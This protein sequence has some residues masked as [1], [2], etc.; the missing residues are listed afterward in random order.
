MTVTDYIAEQRKL[1][2]GT[3][4][5]GEKVG[6]EVG[7]ENTA[8]VK[9]MSGTTINAKGKSFPDK[10]A[11]FFTSLFFPK[12]LDVGYFNSI[13]KKDASSVFNRQ[14]GT[15]YV[16]DRN[17]GQKPLVQLTVGKREAL[18]L[19]YSVSGGIV[20]NQ[21]NSWDTGIVLSGGLGIGVEKSVPITK[22]EFIN[23]CIDVVANSVD[24][25][26]PTSTADIEGF[27]LN[28][29]TGA[30]LGLSCDINNSSPK[31]FPVGSIGGGV[32]YE[33]TMVITPGE[34]VEGT[35]NSG[36]FIMNQ[37]LNKSGSGALG[38]FVQFDY[39]ELDGH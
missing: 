26:K 33:G 8:S 24:I 23:N 32:Y 6:G 31:G 36:V 1:G 2:T 13:D 5:S 11:N 9:A 15:K 16:Y 18:L 29:Y 34:L 19:G 21:N 4:V 27:S 28:A 7:K 22:N 38:R 14:A 17:S 10:L 3:T 39:I 25:T 12:G 20:V 37:I 30:G 35:Y